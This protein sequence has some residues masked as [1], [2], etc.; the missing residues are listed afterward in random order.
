MSEGRF[1][2]EP[3]LSQASRIRQGM[4]TLESETIKV[5]LVDD[6]PEAAKLVEGYLNRLGSVRFQV[7]TKSDGEAAIQ[8]ASTNKSI[9]IILMDYFLPGMNGLEGTKKLKEMNNMVPV[10]FLTVNKDMSLAVE[11]MRA[12]V[13]DYLIKE[14]ITSP[15]FPKAILSAVEKQKLNREVAELEIRKRRLEAM[16]EFVV[17]ITKEITSPLEEMKKVINQ[18]LNG[19]PSEKAAK[20]LSLI[21]ENL[22]RLDSKME[23]L[24]NLKDDRTVQYIK[25]IKMI[26]LS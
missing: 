4:D 17:G 10:V 9:D 22:D 7:T 2:H 18:I 6:S 19:K 26:D 12:G 8:E 21:K 16:Q 13:S 15:V 5:L 24:K 20:Y 3:G 11:A 23:K 1:P 25:D 14:D